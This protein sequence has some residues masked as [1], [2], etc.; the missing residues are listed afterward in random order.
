MSK[1]FKMKSDRGNKQENGPKTK[2]VLTD[3]DACDRDGHCNPQHYRAP[4]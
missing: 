3:D 2:T 4:H 1:I